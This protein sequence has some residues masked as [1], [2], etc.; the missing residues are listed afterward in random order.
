MTDAMILP[1]QKA[2]NDWGDSTSSILNDRLGFI[3]NEWEDGIEENNSEYAIYLS[4]STTTCPVLDSPTDSV[5]G[6]KQ[7]RK[8]LDENTDIFQYYD[9]VLVNDSRTYSDGYTGMAWVGTAGGDYGVGYVNGDGGKTTA[10]HELCHTYGGQH[11]DTKEDAQNGN[12][13]FESTATQ[14]SIMGVYGEWDCNVNQSY[15]YD[16]N[17]FAECTKTAVRDH[18]DSNGL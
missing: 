14:H 4:M 11:A 5:D 17:W 15:T 12:A 18:I 7:S 6:L 1:T 2:K 10:A 13:T 8:W 3:Q 16:G 9:A